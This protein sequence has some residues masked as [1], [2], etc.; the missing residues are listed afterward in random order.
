MNDKLFAR[1][2]ED[3]ERKRA[4]LNERIARIKKDI[5]SGLEPDSGEQATQLENRE[6]LDALANEATAEVALINKALQRMDEG[7]Y[8]LC[9]QCGEQ[10]DDRRL[11]ARPY[12]QR[13]IDCARQAQQS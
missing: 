2:R 13:C 1:L 3:L 9:I 10:I 4:E 11:E 12:A 8:G 6:V 5:T 7:E